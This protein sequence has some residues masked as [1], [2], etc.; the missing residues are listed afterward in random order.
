MTRLPMAFLAGIRVKALSDD[1]CVTSVRHRWINQNPFRSMYFAVQ[2]MAAELSTGALL[3]HHLRES[4]T[5]ASMLVASYRGFF[6]KKATGR[7][8]FTC[9]DGRTILDFL[10]NLHDEA[11]VMELTS[12]G[13]DEAGDVVSEY[14]FT[15]TIRR[16]NER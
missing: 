8:R 7:I 2:S 12:K 5:D 4:G 13:V 6:H 9:E 11:G 16:R 10:R 15:W 3:V 1:R 14:V